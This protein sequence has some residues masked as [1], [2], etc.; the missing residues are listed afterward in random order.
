MKSFLIAL[1]FLTIIPVRIK[2]QY[3]EAEISKSSSAFIVVGFLQGVFLIAASFGLNLVFH[4]D[5][6]IALML[7]ILVASNG[8]F[9]LDGLSDTFDALSV[10]SSG[11]ISDDKEKR[12]SIMKDSTA[13]PI[14]ITAIIF[15]LGLKYLCLKNISHMS[16]YSYYSTLLFMPMASKW[17]MVTA[18]FHG[19][20]ARKDGLGRIFIDSVKGKEFII[21]TIIFIFM[22]ILFQALFSSFA[23]QAQYFFNI[24]MFIFLYLFSHLWIRL[25]N[26]NFGGLTGDTLGAL[27][28]LSELLFLFMVIAWSRLYIL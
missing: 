27:S 20:S 5:I 16:Y 18:M 14:G 8:G 21:S 17:C 10:K 9:H 11:N 12:L 28:E 7:L 24:A 25:C 3:G 13:G 4:Q 2:A 26:K 19:S 23:P 1:Q 15:V 22:L 6:V